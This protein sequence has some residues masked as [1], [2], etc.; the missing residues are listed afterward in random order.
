MIATK[1]R[2]G[3]ANST[4]AEGGIQSADKEND[5]PH[6]HY[7][8]S[9]GGGHYANKPELLK[10]LVMDGPGAIAWLE[11]LG[12]MFDKKPDGEMVSVPG[13]GLSRNRLH[14]CADYTGLEITR[15]LINEVRNLGIPIV[16]FTA[17]LS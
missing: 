2:M 11:S 4:M 5:S 3:D 15:V 10:R 7:L 8:D 13:G 1:L 6:R 9:I 17:A 14:A 16:D 12:V